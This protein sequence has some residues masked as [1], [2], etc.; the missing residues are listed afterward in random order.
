MFSAFRSALRKEMEILCGELVR[1]SKP[2]DAVVSYARK[3]D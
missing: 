3:L 2:S 1:E